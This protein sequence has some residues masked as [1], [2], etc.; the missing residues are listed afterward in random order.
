LQ[1]WRILRRARVV[2]GNL[3][4]GC[5]QLDQE[6]F[7]QKEWLSIESIQENIFAY[8]MLQYTPQNGAGEVLT[9][10]MIN[11]VIQLIHQHRSIRS[12]KNEPVPKDMIEAIVFAGQR[13]STSSNLQM[14][15]VVVTTNLEHRKVLSEISGNQK[16]I[17]QAPLFLTWCA[18]LSRLDRVCEKLGYVHQSGYLENFLLAVVDAAISAQNAGL[19]AESLGL[20]FCYI[21]A[22]RNDP[23]RVSALLKLP[24]LVFPLV[25]MTLG[26]PDGEGSPRPRLPLDAILHWDQYGTEA[27]T[28]RFKEYDAEMIK[29][30]IYKGRQVESG[31][32]LSELEYGWQEHSARRVSQ[33]Q[34][35]HLRKYLTKIGFELK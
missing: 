22:I 32:M 16:H 25:G 8:L 9:K 35:P 3:I 7:S 13:S 12:Y 27:E 29:T 18:D 23:Q 33:I 26:W 20:G 10:K 19:A 31:P 21:G 6:A 11:Q 14:Y 5:H 34:R 30:G 24:R 17:V 1:V 2:N 28:E 15:G 4:V